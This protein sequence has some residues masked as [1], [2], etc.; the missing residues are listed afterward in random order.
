MVRMNMSTMFMMPLWCYSRYSL[1]KLDCLVTRVKNEFHFT[2]LAKGVFWGDH[3]KCIQLMV[4]VVD[5]PPCAN[6]GV[7]LNGLSGVCL[8]YG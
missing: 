7:T 6:G 1:L 5:G 2:S 8:A 3:G 4:S